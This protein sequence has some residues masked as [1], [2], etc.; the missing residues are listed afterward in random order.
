LNGPAT[1]N[2]IERS[3]KESADRI[4][5]DISS[6]RFILRTDSGQDLGTVGQGP[7][8]TDGSIFQAVVK[9][10]KAYQ[11]IREVSQQIS[12]ANGNPIH[13]AFNDDVSNLASIVGENTVV[14]SVPLTFSRVT[15]GAYS[16]KTADYLISYELIQDA[17]LNLTE[18]VS[19]Q[20]SIRLGRRMNQDFTVGDGSGK[21]TGVV[22]SATNA[23]TTASSTAILFDELDDLYHS[24]DP[25][26]RADAVW[27]MSDSTLG[28]LEKSLVDNNNRPLF[29]GVGSFG[30]ISGEAP[31]TLLG[32]KIVVNN[33]MPSIAAGNTAVL[34]GDF[35]KFII[36][37]VAAPQ[38]VVARERWIDQAAVGV[39]AFARADAGLTDANA[40]MG[41]TM[42]ASS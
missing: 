12:T 10:L 34:F 24:V 30:N 37:D 7:E 39:I 1:S 16:Y 42:K 19:E 26:Y 18:L 33:E 5:V 29:L 25:L 13:W 27:M 11:G 35:K 41:L 8:L 38:I 2:L 40:I 17:M 22:T 4:G 31:V 14:T 23:V 6:D 21:P 28:A 15:L 3:W 9:R 20:L 32:K 36:R